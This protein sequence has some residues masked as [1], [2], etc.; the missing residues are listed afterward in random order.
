MLKQMS[1]L[2]AMA[3]LLAAEAA[4]RPGIS[5]PEPKAAPSPPNTTIETV[6][7]ALV[8]K[9]NEY[10]SLS[11]ELEVVT[12]IDNA[13]GRSRGMVTS[14]YEYLRAG[15][16]TFIRQE[17]KSSRVE[18]QKGESI[19]KSDGAITLIADG[20]FLYNLS[21]IWGE[22]TILKM[23]QGTTQETLGGPGLFQTLHGE[24]D[25]KLLPGE[26]IDGQEV[27]VI[28]ALSK[29]PTGEMNHMIY[30]ISKET[31]VALK[32]VNRSNNGTFQTTLKVKNVQINPV[33]HPDRF[34]FKP[35]PG[36]RIVD[37]R[38]SLEEQRVPKYTPQLNPLPTPENK[39]EVA[40]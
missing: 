21:D 13:E 15:G 26:V 29:V 8:K 39:P 11:A 32:M 18:Q 1:P 25:L 4:C 17:G 38:D 31:S 9:W 34:I 23:N 33:L 2:L 40:P 28:E 5:N 36:I 24:Y 35:P 27:Y 14:K 19:R 10:T 16:K 6:E 3:C 7:A 22:P 12:E 20:E 30:Y 37:L